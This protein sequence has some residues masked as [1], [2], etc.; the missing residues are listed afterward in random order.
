MV[1]NLNEDQKSKL[2]YMWD[3]IFSVLKDPEMA[4]QGHFA[5]GDEIASH[6]AHLSKEDKA[7]E[8][9]SLH[10]EAEALKQLFKT[11]GVDEF[12][13]Q[14]WFLFGP[15]IPDM[16]LLK[17]LRA[18]KWNVHRAFA[19]LC[20]CV[21]WRIESKVM[22]L[23]IKGD[24]GLGKEDEKYGL[25]GPAAK[26]FAAGMTDNLM[27]IIYIHVARHIA[28]M[29]SAETMTKF[30]ISSAESFRCLVTYPN[31]KVVIV[32]DLTGFGMKN[33][34]WHSLTTIMSIL[35]AYYPETLS[36]L[37]IHAA[38]WIFQG[39]WKALSPMLDPNVRAKI[40]FT[41]K[42]GDLD[43]IPLNRLEEKLGGKLV[44]PME[45]TPPQP[46][47]KSGMPRN[48]PTFQKAW[49]EYMSQ[50]K[51][52]EE[53]T[54]KWIAT[55]G[56]D[57]QLYAQRDLAAKKTRLAWLEN[58]E[59]FR[60]R[61]MYHR[62]GIITSDFLFDWTYKQKDGSVIKHQVG[63]A[64]T[65]SA[66]KK[67]VGG[68]DGAKPT[69][70]QSQ[71]R[72]ATA[73]QNDDHTGAI[74]GGAAA[75]GA[76][77]AG[78]AG[79]AAE[80]RS[81]HRSSDVPSRRTS[82][83]PDGTVQRQRSQRASR[84]QPRESAPRH[85]TSQPPIEE[86]PQRRRVRQPVEESRPRRSRQ[87]VEAPTTRSRSAK[88]GA[89]AGAGAAVAGGV[90]AAAA[91]RHAGR[92]HANQ[93]DLSYLDNRARSQQSSTA[94]SIR[95]VMSDDEFVDADDFLDHEEDLPRGSMAALGAS[96][97]GA[98]RGSSRHPM[99]AAP[100]SSRATRSSAAPTS[101]SRNGTVAGGAAAAPLSHR[102]RPAQD[103]DE[104]DDDEYD[105][106]EYDEDEY[107]DD[108]IEEDEEEEGDYDEEFE[109]EE[110]YEEEQSAYGAGGMA[111][112]GRHRP[113]ASAARGSSG[114][115]TTAGRRRP[116]PEAENDAHLAGFPNLA[117]PD[118]HDTI[119]ENNEKMREPI[120][121]M[122]N[123][124]KPSLLSRLNCFKTK[125]VN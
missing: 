49:S 65:I 121:P 116:R 59:I 26:T 51:N 77:A 115:G 3:L 105:D 5:P 32:F 102:R 61:T 37:Y 81:R 100:T 72:K 34:D 16:I 62:A 79:A 83:G 119:A 89:A 4:K 38:P 71:R 28:K 97:R 43:L 39:I 110:G 113:S 19:M 86:A 68:R 73:S 46:G 117:K 78:A 7:K 14:L 107:D 103:E 87:A 66:L 45:W 31:D 92:S 84:D 90:G 112:G 106:E 54:R 60:G 99:T 21:K 29:Q 123:K 124:K 101:R 42:P 11:H 30:V 9:K 22:E 33:M 17:F 55:D 114:R 36:K 1:C 8:A 85:R 13:E 48:D 93:P 67:E 24:L 53:I 44:D 70:S 6:D 56:Q 15:D 82:R 120:D 91:S 64:H 27:P 109:D 111:A 20:K 12:Y 125:N 108:L 52:Y 122:A 10:E 96:S 58:D 18:R 98:S 41:G 104:Y 75:G 40:D 23:V 76:V 88:T 94:S 2:S 74:A 69:S 35:E 50:A 47:E 25:Q 95:S 118:A 63:A 57:D 80:S